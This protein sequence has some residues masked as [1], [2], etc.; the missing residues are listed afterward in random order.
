MGKVNHGGTVTSCVDNWFNSHTYI[1]IINCILYSH[2]TF[3]YIP[4]EALA[5]TIGI[6]FTLIIME[7]TSLGDNKCS[8][9]SF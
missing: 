3:T 6:R 2:S 4:I 7:V 9:L 5:D 8:A 1:D